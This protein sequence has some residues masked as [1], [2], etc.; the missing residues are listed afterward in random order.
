[1][2]EMNIRTVNQLTFMYLLYGDRHLS[3]NYAG[4]PAAD[5]EY[6]GRC[7][8]NSEIG[9][10]GSQKSVH[11]AMRLRLGRTGPERLVDEHETEAH[12]VNIHIR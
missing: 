11:G 2:I 12:C 9:D 1:M 8:R 7:E 10:A 4:G 3:L 5:A 6:E